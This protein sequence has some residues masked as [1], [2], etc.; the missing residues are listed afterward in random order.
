MGERDPCGKGEVEQWWCDTRHETQ[1]YG[2]IRIQRSPIDL[3][4][5]DVEWKE[6]RWHRWAVNGGKRLDIDQ[7][8]HPTV[9]TTSTMVPEFVF[10][11]NILLS[12]EWFAWLCNRVD[13]NTHRDTHWAQQR[14]P[15]VNAFMEYEKPEHF[16][17]IINEWPLF[18][19]R[20][21]VRDTQ[22]ARNEPMRI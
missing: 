14:I 18:L 1:S 19:T 15:N 9:K 4:E 22:F 17:C 16:I 20:T 11:F 2:S 3:I 7:T 10:A 6:C 21:W 12:F 8:N 5:S 13:R